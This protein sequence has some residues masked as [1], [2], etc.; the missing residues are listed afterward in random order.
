M[1]FAR[2]NLRN[3][4]FE[5]TWQRKVRHRT[6]PQV[7]YY[8]GVVIPELA[9]GVGYRRDEHYQLHD[10]LMHKFWPLEPDKLTKAPRRR[11][12]TL[13]DKGCGAPLTDEEMGIHLE[14]VIILAAEEGVVI[15]EADKA[16]RENRARAAR[17]AEKPRQMTPR[18]RAET[19]PHTQDAAA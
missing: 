5:I 7:A 4:P 18:H 11:R 15:P 2:V 17:Q 3:Q 6:T 16:Y 10:G 9:A 8:F 12:L 14:Q 13:K 1:A 19:A